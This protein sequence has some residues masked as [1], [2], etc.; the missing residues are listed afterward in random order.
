MALAASLIAALLV[1]V[2]IFLI[3]RFVDATV[4]RLTTRELTEMARA[5]GQ[6]VET[7]ISDAMQTAATLDSSIEALIRSGAPGRSDVGEMLFQIVTNEPVLAGAW[8]GAEPNAF[9]GNDIN[10]ER[11]G[12]LAH[13]ETGHFRPY[14]YNFGNGPQR[15]H[16][17]FADAEG[18][19][20]D[21]YRIPLATG[22]PY[23]TNPVPYV[24]QEQSVLLLSAT[25][26]VERGGD[27]I[28]VVGVDIDLMALSERFANI[29]PYGDGV[30]RL[31][32]HD[33]MWA[34]TSEL[35]LLGERVSLDADFWPRVGDGRRPAIPENVQIVEGENGLLHLLSPVHVR[36]YDQ[37]W[38]VV[39]SVPKATVMA[40][41]RQ[42][43]RVV[44]YAGIGLVFSVVIALLI[45]SHILIRRPIHRSID[46]I[47]ALERGELTVAIPQIR[48]QDEIGDINR[49][50]RSFRDSMRQVRE[51]EAA[52]RAKSQ[53]LANMSHE[54]RTPLNGVLAASQMLDK[55]DLSD[56]QAEY[57]RIIRSS[58]SM[59]FDLIR[60]VLDLS[61]IESGQI[62][63]SSN[64]FSLADMVQRSSDAVGALAEKKSLNLSVTISPEADQDFQGDE[65][66]I[67]Q[68]VTNLAGN[69]VK[70]TDR[71][72][73]SIRVDRVLKTGEVRIEVEDT[74]RGIAKANL[75][76]VFERF[77]QVDE[78]DTRE[79]G[80]SGLGLAISRQFARL[81]GGDI[82]ARSQ[83]GE[84][85]CFT[86]VLP[87]EQ[88]E[89]SHERQTADI[90]KPDTSAPQG[91]EKKQM[92]VLV[93]E[94]VA[95][96]RF[97]L[98]QFLKS[99]GHSVIEAENGREALDR[100]NDQA[101]IDL[102]LMD[103]QMP[104][105]SGDDALREIRASAESYCDI[106]VVM[107]TADADSS[108]SDTLRQAG[109]T[110]CLAKPV[111]FINLDQRIT[112]IV[113]MRQA[114]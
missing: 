83:L 53:F 23:L 101:G 97:L 105:M 24:I 35:A 14:V 8:F 29:Q 108:T 5:E 79:F 41:A 86:V 72:S 22:L 89:A 62:V 31:I 25:Y 95:S 59:L 56:D 40:D 32:S 19:Q 16:L 39:I 34:A 45:V 85:S 82:T 91:V 63:L 46:T 48:R 114:A 18:A 99:A 107:V 66:R 109:A 37:P 94:D 21:F 112:E 113:G 100:L 1:I 92:N 96:N 36:Q 90:E 30:I 75:G 42:I 4:S 43:Q 80:G 64:R 70:F 84:G 28:G 111:D 15:H 104:V 17:N 20:S 67:C 54:I 11:D 103:L 13:P 55:T 68:I 10:A 47:Q 9:D 7:Q 12:W 78:S 2:C 102:V 33:Q 57:L 98:A 51:L 73:V 110:A 60:D 50:L 61:K 38:L 26:P 77:S 52:G 81:M 44:L 74:G 58:G 71:G 106:P 6:R 27:V 93:V 49:A 76:R 65:T 3:S 88:I 87:L 69:A